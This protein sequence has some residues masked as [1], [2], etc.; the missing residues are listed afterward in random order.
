MTLASA[1]L[2]EPTGAGPAGSSC[3]YHLRELASTEVPVEIT[4][5]EQSDRVG[6][7][8]KLVHVDDELV[9]DFEVG[10]STFSKEDT[11]LMSTMKVL[12][13]EEVTRVRPIEDIGVWDGSRLVFYQ[14]W[15][16][17]NWRKR[18]EL[19]WKYG[20]APLRTEALAKKVI[21]ELRANFETDHSSLNF[22]S[23]TVPYGNIEEALSTTAE[24][25]LE[26]HNILPP[27]STEII[28]A[29]T[30]KRY[31]QNLATLHGLAAMMAMNTED[32]T[33]VKGG[34]WRLFD[35][36]VIASKARLNLN[37]RVTQI[38]RH[39]NGTF[40]IKW[41]SS[42]TVV[43]AIERHVADFDAVIVAVPAPSTSVNFEPPL[44][45]VS[46]EP[47][48][49]KRHVT[50]FVTP[51]LLNPALF[52]LPKTAFPPN[53]LRTTLNASDGSEPGFFQSTIPQRVIR[54]SY[55]EGKLERVY[56]FITPSHLND[57]MIAHL[58]GLPHEDGTPLNDFYVHWV[59][60]QAWSHGYPQLRPKTGN[61]FHPISPARNLY[62]SSEIERIESSLEMSGLMGR[63]IARLAFRDWKDGYGNTNQRG[64][65]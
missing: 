4:I 63:N 31:A 36:M 40:S 22:R 46:K 35:E 34:D 9:D 55:W 64:V 38:V 60:R 48:Y 33:S 8:A 24:A 23:N 42:G 57:T 62:F 16:T 37:S 14:R 56:K 27:Y 15:R 2:I 13:L 6:G 65:I 49:V 5:F 41:K 28:Q 17:P 29:S 61:D 11:L 19:F 3:A 1:V 44:N 39:D 43:S 52:D 25:Y 20:L 59:H 54:P 18:A 21:H 32:T 50:H 47:R 58:L 30:R 10:A 7:R 12:G 26:K 51:V 45:T 53:D